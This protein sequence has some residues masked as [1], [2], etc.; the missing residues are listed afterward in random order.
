MITSEG[1]RLPGG[2]SWH[3]LAAPTTTSSPI[4]PLLKWWCPLLS[5]A[6]PAANFTAETPT[7][8]PGMMTHGAVLAAAVALLPA[9]LLLLPLASAAP[10]ATDSVG[11]SRCPTPAGPG[12]MVVVDAPTPFYTWKECTCGP[13]LPCAN[14]GNLAGGA[15]AMRAQAQGAQFRH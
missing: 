7:R 9:L 14:A 3:L 15:W 11:A 10:L 12:K 2:C 5:F 13:A 4:G 6:S 8:L 1:G